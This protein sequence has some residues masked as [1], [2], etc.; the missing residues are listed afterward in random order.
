VS[1]P[2]GATVLLL[3]QSYNEAKTLA[4]DVVVIEAG[5]AVEWKWASYHCHSVTGSLPLTDPGAPLAGA[6]RPLFDSG[7][8]YPSARPR[9]SDMMGLAAI[10]GA[11]GFLDYPIPDLERQTLS[12]VHTFLDPGVYPYHCVHHQEIG[13]EGVVVVLPRQ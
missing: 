3:H 10:P 11:A 9:A 2:I 5:Q 4:P 13:M 8:L 12:F 1:G 7:F 6:G